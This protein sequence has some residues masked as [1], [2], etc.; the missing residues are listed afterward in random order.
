MA[1]SKSNDTLS[2]ISNIEE[3][4]NVEPASANS[5]K[6]TEVTSNGIKEKSKPTNNAT[7]SSNSP[8]HE[9]VD[10][11]PVVNIETVNSPHTS[12]TIVNMPTGNPNYESNNVS[13]MS[14]LTLPGNYGDN[15]NRDASLPDA[16]SSLGLV[17]NASADNTGLDN[18]TQSNGFAISQSTPEA[19]WQMNYHEAAI[20]LQVRSMS[21]YYYKLL[22]FFIIQY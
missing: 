19:I 4:F 22:T 2:L 10:E 15:D 21:I 1:L 18:S 17:A 12:S 11:I 14:K 8:T 13:F 7:F 9:N 3:S 5:D 16:S 6:S 20:F